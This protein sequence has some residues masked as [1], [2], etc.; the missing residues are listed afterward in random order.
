MLDQNR[1]TL[2]AFDVSRLRFKSNCFNV[3]ICR[4]LQSLIVISTMSYCLLIYEVI[5]H[6][7]FAS[8]ILCCAGCPSKKDEHLKLLDTIPLYFLAT[9]T[10]EV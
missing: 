10:T 7:S 2:A 1:Q 6:I 5:D 9:A 3:V 4:L 8:P